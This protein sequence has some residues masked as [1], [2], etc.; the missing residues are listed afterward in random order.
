M[1][2]PVNGYADYVKVRGEVLP[3]IARIVG[4]TRKA[5]IDEQLGPGLMGAFLLYRGR[6]LARWT[7]EVSL[8]FVE[9]DYDVWASHWLAEVFKFPKGP[10]YP[11][12]KAA[13]SYD[14]VHPILADAGIKQ[15]A[16]EEIKG[17]EPLEHGNINKWSLSCIEFVPRP[18]IQQAKL[19]APEATPEDPGDKMIRE[20][21]AGMQAA[22]ANNARA[23]KAPP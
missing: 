9:G 5:K 17:P 16:L 22:Q 11:G 3:G 13:I 4:L 20:A 10:V 6:N 18:K 8:G 21:L 19:D 7:I 1:F 2:D 14:V 15:F 23:W 12:V